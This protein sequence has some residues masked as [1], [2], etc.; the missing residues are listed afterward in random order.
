VHLVLFRYVRHGSGQIRSIEFV[1]S[2]PFTRYKIYNVQRQPP[3]ALSKNP[4][5]DHLRHKWTALYAHRLPTL[6]ASHSPAQPHWPVHLDHCFARIILDDAIGID[7]PWTAKLKAPAVKNMSAAQLEKC[8]ALGEG[9]AEGREDLVLLDGR[10]LE[11]R[12]KRAK[13]KAK[14]EGGKRGL[15]VGEGEGPRRKVAR[16]GSLETSDG[17]RME[18]EQAGEQ[19]VGEGRGRRRSAKDGHRQRQKQTDIRAAMTGAP[20]PPTVPSPPPPTHLPAPPPNPPQPAVPTAPQPPDN[21]DL[22]NLITTTPH[23]TPYRK[24]VLLLLTQVPPGHTTTYAALATFLHSS[25]RAVGNAMRNNPFAPHV[26]CHRV[27]AANGEI[28][29]F[30]GEWGAGGRHAGE[31]RRLLREEGVR[32]D[33][34]GRVVGGGWRGFR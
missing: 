15:G 17:V 23:L 25:P 3:M 19:G 2:Q 8:I 27:L 9:I 22:T 34:G 20:P 13:V 31:K 10:S 21:N 30:G 28:G 5:P 16:R 18:E 29:G 26:P 11:M 12:G 24:S 14:A 4:P 7:A 32:F 6:A 1:T 33:G